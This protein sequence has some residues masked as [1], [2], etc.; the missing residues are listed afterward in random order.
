AEDQLTVSIEDA[1]TRP[2]SLEPADDVNKPSSSSIQE[3]QPVN[4]WV[5]PDDPGNPRNWK[6]SVKWRISVIVSL[7]TLVSPIAT[8]MVAPALGT[9]A[10][11]F[12]DYDETDLA[13][14]MTIFVL[15]YAIGP[16]LLAPLSE[17]YGRNVIMQA[18]NAF[19]CVFNLLCGFAVNREQLIAFR[20]FAGLG[21]SGPIVIGGGII[22]DLFEAKERGLAMAMFAAVVLLGPTL[23]PIAGGFMTQSLSWHWTF[24]IVSMYDVLIQI[25]GLFALKETYA[26]VI[27]KWRAQSAGRTGHT[28]SVLKVIWTN[29]ERPFVL[30]FTQPIVFIMSV[31]MMYLYGIYY[32]VL[33]TFPQIWTGLY[34]ESIGIGGLN[35]LSIGIGSMIG[36]I[37]AGVLVDRIFIRLTNT[38]GAGV[39]SPEYRIPLLLP[40]SALIP[41]G[42]ILYGWATEKHLHWV[43]PNLGILIFSAGMNINFQVIT[44]YIVD[45]YQL[46]S[47]SAL[48]ATS[49]L[50]SVAGFGFPLFAESMYDK[51]NYGWGNTMLGFIAIAIGFPSPFFFWLYGSKL[52]ARSNYAA[53]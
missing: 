21:G 2:K 38:R 28:I 51:L 22:T 10:V 40:G 30:L 19:F 43:L 46:Y 23:G 49:F 31:Y 29:I 11:D 47:A 32:I 3:D 13:I 6:K 5:G 14:I 8:S 36:T 9:V 39:S 4:D 27:L 50:R 52:R 1:V 33:A 26:P 41:I 45:A 44:I 16:F 37:I 15:A 53:G 20:F 48:A 7:F 34:G 17:I 12:H 42:L 24:Y 25:V 35:Y 18:S